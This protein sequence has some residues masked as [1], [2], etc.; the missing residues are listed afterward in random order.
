[1][2]TLEDLKNLT[3][4]QDEIRHIQDKID[5]YKPA[6]IVVDAVRGSSASFPFT[7]H[8]ITVEGLEKKSSNLSKHFDK[9]NDYKDKLEQEQK[10]IEDEIEQIPYS[11][12]RQIIR[13]HYIEQQSYVQ[14]MFKMG[15]GAPETPRIKLM[16]YLDN[17]KEKE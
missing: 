4:L 8:T 1:M 14:I 13:L 15:Y 12:I 2:I 10:R 9:L 7:E 17:T 11:E 16:R 6:E 3:Y 5:N